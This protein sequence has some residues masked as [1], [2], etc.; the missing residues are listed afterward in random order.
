MNLQ[1]SDENGWSVNVD[2]GECPLP[3]R[4]EYWLSTYKSG[5]GERFRA[6]LTRQLP[7]LILESIDSDFERTSERHLRQAI[8]IA[9]ALGVVLPRDALLFDYAAIE[10]IDA[11]SERLPLLRTKKEHGGNGGEVG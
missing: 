8:D 4:W 3:I 6:A 5:F 1:F 10:F 11:H 2:L 7:W 9:V